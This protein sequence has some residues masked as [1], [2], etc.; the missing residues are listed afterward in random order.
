MSIQSPQ[1]LYGH[2]FINVFPHSIHH[3]IRLFNEKCDEPGEQQR[4]LHVGL[5]KLRDTVIQVEQLCQTLTL[6][7]A[8]LEANEKLKRMV[9]E[10]QEV[11]CWKAASIEIQEAPREQDK[12][13]AIRRKTV[14][15]ELAGAEPAVIDAQA[16]VKGIKKTRLS[17]VRTM[18]NPPEAVKL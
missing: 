18:A 4:H 3:Y 10:Q 1:V 16:A 5:A 13:V 12:Y 11:E 17:E 14:M 2:Y 9:A 15:A 8:Q 6:K 7:R